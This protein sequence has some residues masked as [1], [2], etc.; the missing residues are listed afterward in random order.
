MGILARTVSP[1]LESSVSSIRVRNPLATESISGRKSPRPAD[2]PL[3]IMIFTVEHPIET[4]RFF[5]ATRSFQDH[6]RLSR[7][8]SAA[9][10]A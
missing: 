7:E 1:S 5:R 3:Q 9:L 4:E 8:R 2:A 10:Y 6:A